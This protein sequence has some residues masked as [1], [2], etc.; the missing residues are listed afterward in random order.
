LGGGDRKGKTDAGGISGGGQKKVKKKSDFFAGNAGMRTRAKEGANKTQRLISLLRKS[1]NWGGTTKTGSFR[2]KNARTMKE[3]TTRW[4]GT[5]FEDRKTKSKGG[6][7][8]GCRRANAKRMKEGKVIQQI[9]KSLRRNHE[10][11]TAKRKLWAARKKK[12]I[13]SPKHFKG[14]PVGSK[15]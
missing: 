5:P 11:R 13:E 15:G 10:N 6:G 8:V 12:E 2:E 1:A 7:P 4:A 14:N 9:V 3:T